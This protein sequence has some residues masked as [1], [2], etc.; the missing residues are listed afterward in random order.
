MKGW[1]TLVFNA[2][3]ALAGVVVAFNWADVLPAKYAILVTSVAVPMING[4]L[5]TITDTPV[6]K[7]G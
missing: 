4:W 6:G 5:R 2:A 1:R 3:V 7:S